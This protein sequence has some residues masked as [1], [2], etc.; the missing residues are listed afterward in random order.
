MNNELNQYGDQSNQI[1][2]VTLD[3]LLEIAK[4][5]SSDLRIEMFRR[6]L[7]GSMNVAELAEM[8]QIPPSTA[9]A[10]IRKLEEVGLIRTE[11]VPGTRGSQKLCAAVLKRI[12]VDTQ[13]TEEET[14][15]SC[16]KTSMPIGNFF[17]YEVSPT[18]GLVSETS[19]IGEF[20]DIRSFSEPSRTG[21]QLIWFKQG[22]LEYRFPNRIPPGCRMT[23][24][25]LSMEL[26]SEAP[27]YCKDWPSDITIWINGREIGTWTSPGEFGGERGFLTPSWWDIQYAQFG[28]LKRWQVSNKGTLVDGLKISDVVLSD[29]NN[30]DSPFITVRIGVKPDA[31][32]V[33]GLNLFGRMFG[34]YGT[35]ILLRLDYDRTAQTSQLNQSTR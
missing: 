1:L 6:L 27:L 23:S 19:I 18:C 16:V 25:E 26:C 9:S 34:N 14:E 13:E 24:L 8:F 3:D 22:Y 15:E 31:Q 7:K 21:A 33:G 28:L 17:D 5:L 11:L 12:I 29:L 20:D 2:Y 10:N 4:A 30:I 35:D 32:N